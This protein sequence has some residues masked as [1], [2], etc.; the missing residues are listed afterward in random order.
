MDQIDIRHHDVSRLQGADAAEVSRELQ[1]ELHLLALHAMR[2]LLLS[3][4]VVNAL[5]LL[6]PLIA[7]AESYFE[8]AHSNSTKP[9]FDRRLYQELIITGLRFLEVALH[10]RAALSYIR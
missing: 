9:G 5:I 1:H 8:T 3:A 6:L 4:S 2:R 7:A 10:V